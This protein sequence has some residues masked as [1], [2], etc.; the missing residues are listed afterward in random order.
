MTDL[1]VEHEPGRIVWTHSG[2]RYALGYVHDHYAI[3]DKET[4][5]HGPL[6]AFPGSDEGW[7]MALARFRELEPAGW[8]TVV[9]N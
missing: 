1:S 9:E 7:E 3:F 8:V 2:Y 4:W 5:Q 6:L